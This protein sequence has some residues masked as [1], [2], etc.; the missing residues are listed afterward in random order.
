VKLFGIDPDNL[1]VQAVND[2]SSTICYLGWYP[3]QV[4]KVG[5]LKNLFVAAR[6][7][8]SIQ[9]CVLLPECFDDSRCCSCVLQKKGSGDCKKSTTRSVH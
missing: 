7:R 9:V 2:V 8:A 4:D 6:I 3:V 1:T 5:R